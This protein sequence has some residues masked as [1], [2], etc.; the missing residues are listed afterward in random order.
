M[1]WV[2]EPLDLFSQ[3]DPFFKL[4]MWYSCCWM[5]VLFSKWEPREIVMIY[6]SWFLKSIWGRFVDKQGTCCYS[7]FPFRA[8]THVLGSTIETLVP[9]AV[10]H[11]FIEIFR[12]VQQN[13][14]KCFQETMDGGSWQFGDLLINWRQ[15]SIIEIPGNLCWSDDFVSNLWVPI[16]FFLVDLKEVKDSS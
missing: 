3:W 4:A 16:S 8:G 11:I 12:S 2:F 10:R 13:V 14:L 5:I 15:H 1:C 6:G 9:C 7:R